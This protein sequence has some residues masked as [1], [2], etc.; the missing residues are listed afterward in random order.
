LPFLGGGGQMQLRLE[1]FNI[2]DR[3]NFS[4]PDRQ[5]FAGATATDPVLPSAGRISRTSNA[6]RQVQLGIKVLF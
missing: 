4:V 6:A 3:A 1:V 5:I 2:F